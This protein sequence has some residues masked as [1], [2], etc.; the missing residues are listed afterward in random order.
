MSEWLSIRDAAQTLGVSDL[1]VRR[2]IKDGR[3]KHTLRDGKYFV[4]LAPD[5]AVQEKSHQG[6]EREARPKRTVPD[7]RTESRAP[8][9]GNGA[10]GLTVDVD[11]LINQHASLAQ[12]A[13]RAAQLE[14][15]LRALE[16]RYLEL[17]QGTIALATRNGWLESKLEERER[18]LKLLE[19]S[20]HRRSWLQ[21]LF[22]GSSNGTI[23]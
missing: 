6:S 1:T 10:S 19:D 22:G 11:A 5:N 23:S 13:G 12:E 16:G 21:R 2:R 20:Q 14:E 17:Q 9:N 7:S 8:S 4:H 18:D 3:I 15:Q